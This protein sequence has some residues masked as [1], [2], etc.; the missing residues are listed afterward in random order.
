MWCGVQLK[1]DALS[2]KPIKIKVVVL[3]SA[4]DHSSAGGLTGALTESRVSEKRAGRH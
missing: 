1:S 4:V 2:I 3:D